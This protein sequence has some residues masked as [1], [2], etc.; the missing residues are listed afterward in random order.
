MIIAAMAIVIIVLV[1]INY[2]RYK[3]NVFTLVSLNAAVS[4]KNQALLKTLAALEQ[5]HTNNTRLL[6]VVAH[7]LRGP[8]GAITSIAELAGDGMLPTEKYQEVM[9]IIFRSG[10]KALTLANH[11]LMDMQTIGQ[12]TNP[13]PLNI[14]EQLSNCVQLYDHRIKEKQQTMELETVP[15]YVSGDREKL[16]RVFSNLISNAIKFTRVNGK[17]QIS[18]SLVN[19]ELIIAFKDNG[20][21]IPDDMKD[22]IFEPTEATTRTGTNGE[23]SFGLGLS[24]S[25]NIIALHGGSLWF[26]SHNLE[27]STFFISLPLMKKEG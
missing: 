17:I 11:L 3:K 10:T 20:I 18:M 15:A 1:W 9:A 8:L 21:G 22:R 26:E 4:N 25:K 24:I 2:R 12:L 14:T 19:D 16:W 5:S 27:G 7:D 13:E 23:R 6:K